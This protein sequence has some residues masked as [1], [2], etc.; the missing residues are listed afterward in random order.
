MVRV[1]IPSPMALMIFAI[2]S[3]TAGCASS[4]LD[5]AEQ[6]SPETI[7]DV[8]A[9]EDPADDSSRDSDLQLDGDTAANVADGSDVRPDIP[10]TPADGTGEPTDAER[11]RPSDSVP[12]AVADAEPDTQ[13]DSEPDRPAD[14]ELDLPRDV[15]TDTFERPPRPDVSSPP[16]NASWRYGGGA[17]YPDT[18]DPGWPIVVEVATLEQLE[19]A[20][21]TAQPGAIVYVSDDAAIDLADTSVCIP[22]G[23]W[24]AGG[25]GRDG[26]AGGVLFTSGSLRGPVITIC[27][28]D[29][30]ITGLRILGADGGT[31]HWRT[32]RS[33]PERLDEIAFGD[34]DGDGATDVFTAGSGEWRW[35]RSGSGSWQH[36]NTSGYGLDVLA[37]ADFDGDGVTDVFRATGSEWQWSRSGTSSWAHLNRS[38][39]RL[40]QLVFADFDGDGRDDALHPGSAVFLVSWGASSPWE[41]LRI[42]SHPV[43][44]FGVGDFDG[45]GVDD[46]FRTG[47]L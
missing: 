25:R 35:S 41:Q 20:L 4:A 27:G 8:Q 21:S 6:P 47:C 1:Q 16:A 24:L 5:P 46:V 28:D 3:S 37:F 19:A 44:S 33:A 14:M 17:G 45:D 9:Q 23:V 10:D 2:I 39:Y 13:V 36:L 26:S 29:V 43:G 18:M 15:E 12:D 7:S 32:L 11:D 30:R 38:N 34:F 40:N 42:A 31:G 22:E